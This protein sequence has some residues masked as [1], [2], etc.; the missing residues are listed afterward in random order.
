MNLV[1]FSGHTGGALVCDLLNNTTSPIIGIAIDSLAHDLLKVGD[2]IGGTVHRN[3]D[4][5]VWANKIAQLKTFEFQADWYG[6]H[7]HP[8]VMSENIFNQFDKVL[9]ITTETM[10]SKLFRYLRFAHI[11]TDA[12]ENMV[13]ESFESDS[14]CM[15][16]EFADIVNGK[17][18]SDNNLSQEHYENWKKA[19]SFLFD[20]DP[21][22][23]EAFNKHFGKENY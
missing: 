7:T 17:F 16:V 12:T 11:L 19:N 22:L 6:T 10:E 8:S 20:P 23:V 21:N 1:C 2:G 4:E 14:R 5:S 18:V 13:A 15:N 9:A 3:F